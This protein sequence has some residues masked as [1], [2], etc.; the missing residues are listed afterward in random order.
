[1]AGQALHKSRILIAEDDYRLS[2]RI[3]VALNDIGA[4][5]I[6]PAD[7]IEDAL[8][9]VMSSSRID[10]A[11][12]SVSLQGETTFAAA[13]HL[14]RRKIPFVFL[15]HLETYAIP[16]EFDGVE[17]FEKPIDIDRLVVRIA[18]LLTAGE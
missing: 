1:M 13:E 3:S 17:R 15:T 8:D 16:Q 7:T 5:C 10:A 11:V 2:L 6:Y 12:I 4:N 9:H 14:V 18:S